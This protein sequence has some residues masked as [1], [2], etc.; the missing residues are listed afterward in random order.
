MKKLLFTFGTRPEA[1][2]MLPII[3]F[4]RRY[5][6][7]E[8]VVKTCVTGQHREM[9]DQ[10]LEFF[11]VTPDYDLDIMIPGQDL[12]DVTAQAL[13]GLRPV[14]ADYKP[15]CVLV[16]GDTTTTLAASLAAYYQRI[17]VA[18]VEAGLRTQ[19]I[20]SPWPEEI[21]RTVTSFVAE[22]HFAPTEVNKANLSRVNITQNVLVAGNSVID[23]LLLVSNKI[24][25]DDELNRKLTRSFE[26]MGLDFNK[27]LY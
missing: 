6:A 18:H 20:Y 3:D 10:V 13:L 26:N 11:E 16:H 12:Y 25:N 1:I 4:A 8:F 2:K 22:F 17:P 14:L 7:Y 15:D 27:K 5:Y 9:L 21:N 23:A 24:N 19:N